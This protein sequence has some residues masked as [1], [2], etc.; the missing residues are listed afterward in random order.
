[1]WGTWETGERDMKRARAFTLIELLVVIAIIAI[2]AAI[3]LPALARAKQKA[4][5]VNCISNLK[6]LGYA[7]VIYTDENEGRFSEGEGTDMARGEWVVALKDAYRR[8]PALLKC[9]SATKLAAS[10][11]AGTTTTCFA[12][13]IPDPDLPS[14]KLWASY[15]LNVW[16]YDA[17]KAIQD[18][19]PQGH[20]GKISNATKPTETPLMGDCKWRGGGPGHRPDHL[21]SNALRPLGGPDVWGNVDYEIAHYAM[22]RHGKGIVLCFFDGSA[23]QVSGR[24]LWSDLQWSRHYD[25]VYAANYLRSQLQ[26]N[27]IE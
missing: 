17:K 10:G 2:L 14:N 4:H 21:G 11:Q 13:N 5:A 26:G 8:K 3:L 25:G 23:R 12:F 22:K 20:W 1:M 27:W 19:Q 7:W 15:G 16:S 6:Q 24:R 9:P 18:R